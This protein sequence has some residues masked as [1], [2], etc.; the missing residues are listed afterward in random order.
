MPEWTIRILAAEDDAPIAGARVALGVRLGRR[1]GV[2]AV[3]ETDRDGMT[4]VAVDVQDEVAR[5]VELM[6][7]TP[8][9]SATMMGLGREPTM[10]P[11]V[12][13]LGPGPRIHGRVTD[14]HGDPVAGAAIE[15]RS[16]GPHDE[17]D[18]Y[19]SSRW[20]PLATT[21][22]EGRYELSWFSTGW[23][24]PPEGDELVLFVDH[25][26]FEPWELRGVHAVLPVTGEAVF[27][28][29][30][31]PRRHPA[32]AGALD[33]PSRPEPRV[34][35]QLSVVGGALRRPVPEGTVWLSLLEATRFST[36]VPIE[37]DGRTARRLIPVGAYRAQIVA[38]EM[39]TGHATVR[40]DASGRCF[41]SVVRLVRGRHVRG[42]VTDPEDRPVADC[43]VQFARMRAHLTPERWA[44]TDARGEYALTGVQGTCWIAFQ[45][46][47]FV[48][49]TR[50]LWIPGWIPWR[51]RLDVALPRGCTVRGVVVGPDDSPRP[52][53]LVQLH[54]RSPGAQP[55]CGHAAWTDANGR[56]ELRCVPAGKALLVTMGAERWIACR[57]GEEVESSRC[58]SRIADQ[59]RC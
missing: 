8:G 2:L 36:W 43:F 32:T 59:P 58:W 19:G 41:P 3:A 34:P 21:D 45:A 6:A 20:P 47:G 4:R 11:I 5:S 29:Q 24:V 50:I 40:V 28:A 44:T 17:P 15:L 9:R 18:W 51:R 38:P 35:L 13:R 42:R 53:C 30:L 49:V 26:R 25:P 23:Q 7:D 27:D 31:I 52:K 37:R 12:L 16:R 1:E 10:D 54:S 46:A 39:A 57:E 48:E 22:V 33:R 56:F 14:A 55:A